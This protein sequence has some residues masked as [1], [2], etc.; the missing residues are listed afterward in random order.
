MSAPMAFLLSSRPIA[1]TFS[2]AKRDA[3][4]SP[5]LPWR[6]IPACSAR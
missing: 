6:T 4:A 5:A 2:W 1:C 3:A